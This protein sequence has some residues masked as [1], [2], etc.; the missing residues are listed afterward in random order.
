MGVT[1]QVLQEAHIILNSMK[2]CGG[3]FSIRTVICGRY[4]DETIP[5]TG[6]FA[7]GLMGSLYE[8]YREHTGI[9]NCDKITFYYLKLTT[10]PSGRAV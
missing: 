9:F 4:P 2:I 6:C 7:C 1:S 10:H 3:Q 8:E 5:R